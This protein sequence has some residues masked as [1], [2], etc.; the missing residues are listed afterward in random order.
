[1]LQGKGWNVFSTR[2]VRV[3]L[4]TTR[5]R[6]DN[7]F[8]DP[9]YGEEAEAPGFL[10]VS[11]PPLELG[12]TQS[13][14][15]GLVGFS[16]ILVGAIIVALLRDPHGALWD[17]IWPFRKVILLAVIF[18]AMVFV[19]LAIFGVHK[20]NF[21]FSSVRIIDGHTWQRIV[22]RILGAAFCLGITTTLIGA[23]SILHPSIMSFYILILPLWL[24]L[25]VPYFLLVERYAKS[26]GPADELLI[27]GLC[28]TRIAAEFKNKGASAC[29]A[30]PAS[31]AHVHNLL[32]SIVLK[33]LFIPIMLLSFIHWWH[34]WELSS[35]SAI[36]QISLSQWHLAPMALNAYWL[37]S[38][39]FK[40]I[41]AV[42]VTFAIIGYS[43]SA[44][45]F[46]TQFNSTDPTWSGWFVA[47][48]CYPPFN[49]L[50][51]TYVWSRV[52]DVWTKNM[53]IDYPLLSIVCG[54]SILI[55][56]SIYSWA[57]ISFGLRF[58]NLSNRGIICAG[59]YAYVR[60]PAYASKN[61]AWW[62][63]LLPCLLFTPSLFLLTA[64]ALL[65]LNGI[66]VMR[67]FTEERHLRRECHYR[68]YC[69][70]VLWR[71]L[72]GIF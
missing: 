70:K 65:A 26:E 22:L 39:L 52:F 20:R 12:Q 40:L 42:D 60:H 30:L 32:R 56:M 43:T 48:I 61:I 6:T 27:M 10:L 55:L 31:N 47:L 63:S 33:S 46:D 53:Y 18:A 14:L 68:Q 50:I 64:T 71:F 29:L 41:I 69:Q 23:L 44:R 35:H 57:S 13:Q 7:A 54:G 67:A 37:N 66:Y 28:L 19:E 25:L 5:V 9:H 34:S 49:F 16:T 45:I 11:N 51:E 38:S 4:S 15:T 8:A 17:Q 59:P 3:W 36:E 62:I 21:D 1:M 2:Q 58:S 24:I 72:P